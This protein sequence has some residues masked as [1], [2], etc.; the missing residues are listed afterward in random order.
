MECKICKTPKCVYST[1]Y[2]VGRRVTLDRG[3]MGIYDHYRISID[4]TSLKGTDTDEPHLRQTLLHIYN[5]IKPNTEKFELVVYVAFSM[6]IN[7]RSHYV[8]WRHLPFEDF[9]RSYEGITC[10][11]ISVYYN[12]ASQT[13]K[14]P[15]NIQVFYICVKRSK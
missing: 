12:W 11:L 1:L 14:F 10:H 9:L 4:F 6:A 7:F 5:S 3:W 2:T 13:F 15:N 8:P